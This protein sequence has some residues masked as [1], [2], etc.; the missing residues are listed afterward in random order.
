MERFGYF[1]VVYRDGRIHIGG[2]S[3]PAGIFAMNLLNQYYRGD[4]AA[5]L[6]VFQ[7][8]NWKVAD[9]LSKGYIGSADFLKAGDEILNILETLPT[10]KP[11]NLLDTDDE[12]NR[13]KVL[14]TEKNVDLLY[15]YFGS[16]GAVSKQTADDMALDLLPREFDER[17]YRAG[18]ILLENVQ[19]TL[20]FYN[21]LADGMTVAHKKLL[22]FVSHLNEAE[23]LDETHLLPIAAT[24]FRT[25]AFA[26]KYEY[27][28]V[29][30]TRNSKKLVTARKLC[31]DSYYSFILTD[32]FEGLHY[33][34]YPRQCAICKKYFL[35]QSARHQ[36]YCSGTAPEKYKG[37]TISCRKQAILLHRKSLAKDNPITYRYN[38]RCSAIRTEKSRGKL[39]ETQ[40]KILLS[41][42]KN[43]LQRAMS[44]DEYARKQYFVDIERVKLYKD[45]GI[46][47][48]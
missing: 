4:T 43:R 7:Q 13:I 47:T 36:I 6:S 26:A 29:H 11:F 18:K 31:F 9:T 20:R 2:K 35:M 41:L 15:R 22:K 45:A 30:K 27:I 17:V 24:V 5:R 23:R 14:F 42:M 8:Y 21:T 25:D 46:I 44:D 40:A 3:Y 32:F 34:H 1:T 38:C 37:Q 16:V 10:L 12:R 39:T 48:K 28:P 19:A 33:G